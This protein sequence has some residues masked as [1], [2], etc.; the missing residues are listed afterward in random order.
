MRVLSIV[1]LLVCLVAVVQSTYE[2]EPATDA[3]DKVYKIGSI[4]CWTCAV[5]LIPLPFCK[6]V[7][8]CK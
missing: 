1:F 5:A 8:K 2:P 6:K 4:N 7:L 3:P